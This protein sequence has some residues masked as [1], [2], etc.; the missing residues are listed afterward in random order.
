[1]REPKPTPIHPVHLTA[2]EDKS[3]H[4][5]IRLFRAQITPQVVRRVLGSS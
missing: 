2:E 4:Q 3:F 5:F 1:M